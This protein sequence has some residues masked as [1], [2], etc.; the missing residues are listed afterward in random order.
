MWIN[1]FSSALTRALLRLSGRSPLP[2]DAHAQS[3]LAKTTANIRWLNRLIEHV[4]TVNVGVLLILII[5]ILFIVF[6]PPAFV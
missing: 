2:V 1:A 4:L 6:F 5:G 3:K